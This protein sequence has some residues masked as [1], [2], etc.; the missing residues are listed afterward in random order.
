MDSSAERSGLGKQPRNREHAV[1]T[2]IGISIHQDGSP[3]FAAP[4]AAG[5]PP[6]KNPEIVSGSRYPA[7]KSALT[8]SAAGPMKRNAPVSDARAPAARYHLLTKPLAG[9]IPT[10]AREAMV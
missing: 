6:G 2:A 5:S 10:R 4:P 1:K 9:G 7:V 8:S 3:L